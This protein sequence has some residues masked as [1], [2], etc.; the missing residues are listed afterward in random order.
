MSLLSLLPHKESSLLL[1]AAELDDEKNLVCRQVVPSNHPGLVGHFPEFPIWPGHL[2]IEAMAQ[3]AALLHLLNRKQPLR[4]T[5]TPVLGAV[6]CR[7]LKPVFPGDA[8]EFHAKLLRA[9]GDGALFS[10]QAIRNQSAV[11]TARITAGIAQR[12]HLKPSE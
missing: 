4:P 6:Q 9:I 2:L 10:V 8:L 11:A 1:S 3:S 5:E 7:L 12:G